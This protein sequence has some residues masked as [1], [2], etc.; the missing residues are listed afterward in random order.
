MVKDNYGNPDA[1][2]VMYRVMAY[3]ALNDYP[4]VFKGAMVLKLITDPSLGTARGTKDIDADWVDGS[5][6]NG[7]LLHQVRKAVTVVGGSALSVDQTREFAEGRSAQFTVYLY[8]DPTPY[9]SF[10]IAVRDNQYHTMYNMINDIKIRGN[11]I[12]RIFADKVEAISKRKVLRRAKDVYDMFLLSYTSGF[13]TRSI[14]HILEA[15]DLELGDFSDFRTNIEGPRGLRHA[16]NQMRSVDNKPDFD[17][18]YARVMTFLYPFIET[19]YRIPGYEWICRKP[20]KY[21]EWNRVYR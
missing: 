7:I 18:M 9:F 13:R 17:V 11:S 12:D 21:G 1:I 2:E 6:T 5:T 15:H 4:I 19:E 10:D 16:Y 20:D 8:D 14:L 3:M